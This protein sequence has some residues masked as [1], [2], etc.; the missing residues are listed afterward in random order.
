MSLSQDACDHKSSDDQ[1]YH[2]SIRN[3]YEFSQGGH[4]FH[5]PLLSWRNGAR[6]DLRYSYT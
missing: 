2:I 3:R 5:S 6:T 4:Y 1:S